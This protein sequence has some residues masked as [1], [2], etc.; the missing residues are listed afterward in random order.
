MNAIAIRNPI[1]SLRRSAWFYRMKSRLERAGRAWRYLRGTWTESDASQMAYEAHPV[2]GYA[3][4]E[5]IDVD[6]TLEWA[7]ER[8]GDHPQMK[9][10]VER[11]VDRVGYKWSSTG[12]IQSAAQDWAL[13][14][15]VDYAASEGVSLV[16]I[17]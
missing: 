13:D 10:W 6:G 7:T 3:V 14:L 2:A 12:D 15:V 8:Y 17:D 4:L 5:T 9:E 16:A 1:A 11:A